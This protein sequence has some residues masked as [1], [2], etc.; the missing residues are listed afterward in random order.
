MNGRRKRRR[1]EYTAR[2]ENIYGDRLL[3]PFVQTD[4]LTLFR[5]L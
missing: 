3:A 1:C 2:A 4:S 5:Q